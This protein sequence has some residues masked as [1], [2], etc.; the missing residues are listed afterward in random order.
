MEQKGGK[1]TKKELNQMWRR[2]G[3][4]HLSSM[5]YEKLQGHNWAYLMSPLGEK[6]YKDNP[7]AY[8]SLLERHSLFYN[9]EP[10][11]G[12]LIV[13]IAASLEEQIGMGEDVP[14]EMVTSVKATLMGP[15]AGIGDAIMQGIVVPILLSIGMGLASGG[16]AIG[17]VFYMITYGIAGVLI[18]LFAFKNGYKLGLTAVDSLVG[19]NSKRLRDAFNLLGVMVVGGLAASYVTLETKINIP[20]GDTTQKLQEILDSN[21]PKLL[22][23]LMVLLAW[24]LLSSKKMTATKVILILTG[25]SA[26]G[27]VIGIF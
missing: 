1:L 27:V 6:Y 23:L 10:Q 22:P 4:F 11:T 2:W 3:F 18:S 8:R 20:Y 9:T 12:S 16:S 13:G 21:F 19:E 7:E 25:I 26:V 17:P 24:W 15:L 14:E 5:S